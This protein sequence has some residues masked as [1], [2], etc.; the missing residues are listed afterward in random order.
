M[1]AIISYCSSLLDFS[2]AVNRNDRWTATRVQATDEEKLQHRVKGKRKK[3]YFINV[4]FKVP[5]EVQVTAESLDIP[6]AVTASTTTAAAAVSIPL[7]STA[8]ASTVT[9]TIRL[10]KPNDSRHALNAA[11]ASGVESATGEVDKASMKLALD[12]G[13][14]KHFILNQVANTRGDGDQ[15]PAAKRSKNI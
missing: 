1:N 15:K 6:A 4:V 14:S 8:V 5:G 13:Y 2:N 12:A 9:S 3:S 10:T 11:V 7:L